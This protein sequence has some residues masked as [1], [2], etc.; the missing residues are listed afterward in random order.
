MVCVYMYM[1][2]IEKW[3]FVVH[4]HVCTFEGVSDGLCVYMDMHSMCTCTCVLHCRG[5]TF[6]TDFAHIGEIRSLIPRKTNL[7][8]LTDTANLLQGRWLFEVL[9]C[10]G[11]TS[12]HRIQTRETSDI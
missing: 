10:M 6:R 8:A 3:L 11:A 7:M 2:T 4:V 1:Y 9:K 12:K 5:K